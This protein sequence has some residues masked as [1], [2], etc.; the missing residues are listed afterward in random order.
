VTEALERFSATWRIP[1]PTAAVGSVGE[2]G[3]QAA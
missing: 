1:G 2:S 3:I